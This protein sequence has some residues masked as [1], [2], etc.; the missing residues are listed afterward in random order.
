MTTDNRSPIELDELLAAEYNYIAQT[1]A[2]AFEDRARVSSFYLIAV[3]SFIAALFGTQFFDPEQF[4]RGVQ[5]MF[6][7]V[8]LLL[9]FLG[10]STV[11]QLAQLRSAWHESMKAMN[12]IKDFAMTQ[13]PELAN[14][15]RWKTS[16][17]PAKYKRGSVSYYQALEVSLIGGLMFGATTF[18]FQQAFFSVGTLTW[19]ISILFGILAVYVQMANYKRLLM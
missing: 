10:T 4:T 8:F 19:L 9:T 6:S 11:M 7:G 17:L 2:Q 12:Q 15:F 16:T 1:A 3:G 5:L 18:F 14:A 13:H